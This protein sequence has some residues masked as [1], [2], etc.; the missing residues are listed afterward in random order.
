MSNF[1]KDATLISLV[2]GLIRE[3]LASSGMPVDG[4]RWKRKHRNL[5]V[6]DLKRWESC[7]VF[8]FFSLK[9]LFSSLQGEILDDESRN[10]LWCGHFQLLIWADNI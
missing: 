10:S 1:A 6:F 4:C 7:F 2:N 5:L 3:H 9:Y 8:F